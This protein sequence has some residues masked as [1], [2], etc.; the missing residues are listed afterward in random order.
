MKRFLHQGRV[1]LSVQRVLKVAES[2]FWG[3]NTDKFDKFDGL[4]ILRCGREMHR[5]VYPAG[6]QVQ[7][8][9]CGHSGSDGAADNEPFLFLPG[10]NTTILSE[11]LDKIVADCTAKIVTKRKQLSLIHICS[12]S[13]EAQSKLQNIL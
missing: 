6:H 5:P 10:H 3:K 12:F 11:V 7:Q 1:G 9:R 8:Q 2:N 4:H 13:R